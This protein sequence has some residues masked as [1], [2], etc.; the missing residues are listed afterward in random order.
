MRWPASLGGRH[1]AAG[2]RAEFFAKNCLAP[3]LK[4]VDQ[5]RPVRNALTLTI[6]AGAHVR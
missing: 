2:F 4:L 3:R 6:R 1:I 5:F